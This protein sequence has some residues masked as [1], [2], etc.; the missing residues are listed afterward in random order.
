M[1][2]L[3]V[4]PPFTL[5]DGVYAHQCLGSLEDGLLAALP[6]EVHVPYPHPSKLGALEHHRKLGKIPSLQGFFSLMER[7]SHLQSVYGK[8]SHGGLLSADIHRGHPG[9]GA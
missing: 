5:D 1:P 4:M 2:P 8:G 9:E 3:L 7:S 6:G